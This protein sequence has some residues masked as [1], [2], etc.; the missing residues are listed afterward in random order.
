MKSTRHGM[1]FLSCMAEKLE[2]EKAVGLPSVVL[3]VGD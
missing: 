3:V 1:F 2:N